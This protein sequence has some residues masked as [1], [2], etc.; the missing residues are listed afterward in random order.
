MRV[1]NYLDGKNLTGRRQS[2]LDELSALLWGAALF[3]GK[4]TGTLNSGI[5]GTLSW[6][7]LCQL[8]TTWRDGTFIPKH[9]QLRLALLEALLKGITIA[10]HPLHL[11]QAHLLP[12]HQT[13]R[14]SDQKQI[15]AWLKRRIA[16]LREEGRG[17]HH[18]KCWVTNSVQSQIL[19][20]SAQE[21]SRLT[22]RARSQQ[23]QEIKKKIESELYLDAL[24]TVFRECFRAD[25]LPLVS[26][27]LAQAVQTTPGVADFLHDETLNFALIEW[28]VISTEEDVRT[29]VVQFTDLLS[30][31]QICLGL[32]QVID[33]D[34]ESLQ[35]EIKNLAAD[36]S[37]L[38]GMLEDPH[39]EDNWLAPTDAKVE[40]VLELLENSEAQENTTA[41]IDGRTQAA[42]PSVQIPQHPPN[43]H[44][45][46][47]S[48]SPVVLTGLPKPSREGNSGIRLNWK[49]VNTLSGHSDS[50]VSIVFGPL[51]GEN[52]QRSSHTLVSGSWDKSI[53]IWHLRNTGRTQGLPHTLSDHSASVYSV[54]IS[55]DCQ[56]LASGYVDY[57]VRIWHLP[58]SRRLHVLTGH[59]VPI[60]S[61]AFSP[62][63]QLLATGS[64]DQTVKIWQVVTGELLAT[65]IGHSSFV[66][67]V[68]FSPDGQLLVS[69]S[70]DK[71]IKIWQVKTQQLVR[72]L[73]GN[74][75]VTSVSLSPNGDVIASGSLDETIK[76]WRLKA[77]TSEG[78]TRPAPTYTLRGHTAEVLC[79]AIN[80]RSPILASGSHD[81]TIKLWHLETGQPLGTLAGHLDSVNA[82]AFSPNGHFLASGSHDKTIKIWR[83]FC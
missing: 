67:S 81:K 62:D 32:I 31:P 54:A 80:P 64:G 70:A 8:F 35:K 13:L 45:K 29:V 41:R 19:C 82:V 57:S 42:Q 44:T 40:K 33:F 47:V 3:G 51:T 49:C 37:A 77:S 36:E 74:S 73:I 56:F 58:T 2:V 38:P 39:I 16:A 65:L 4:I 50:V 27:F 15:Q 78:G 24:P 60:Y 17:N 26:L 18:S 9:S 53:N 52:S 10:T 28:D 5:L 48:P 72:T 23:L 69:G 25:W 22:S 66:Y 34:L 79:V 20:G 30:N 75:P 83:A 1:V 11:R 61:V 59:S 21:I 71:T 43:R 63:G 14:V 7:Q 12:P 68:A 46:E 6:E 76:L 55:P